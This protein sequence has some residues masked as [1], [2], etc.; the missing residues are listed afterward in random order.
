MR[1][2][3]LTINPAA[4][5]HN[6]AQVQ[7]LAPKAKVLA[8]VKANAYGHGVAAV[9]PAL[10][11]ADGVGVATFEEA[12]EARRLG[13]LKTIGLVEGVFSASEWQRAIDNEFSCVIHHAPQLEWA[14]DN[15]PPK[16]SQTRIV[17]LKYNSGM[18]RLGFNSDNIIEAAHA[19]NRSGYQLI[20]TTHFANADAF[21]HPLNTLQIKRFNALLETLRQDIS[22]DI[23]ASLCNSAGIIHFAQC[24][25]DWVRPGIMLYGSSPINDKSAAQL[26]LQPA[27]TFSTKIMAFQT[28]TA[29]DAIGYGSRWIAQQDTRTALISI[30]YGDGYPR[31]IDEQA[32]VCV[33][34]THVDGAKEHYFCPIRGRVAMDMIVIDISTTP[35][36]LPLNNDVILWGEAP[37]IDDVAAS[38][39]TISYELFCRLSLRPNRL[40]AN[41]IAERLEK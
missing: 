38:A 18:N 15:V 24:H 13:W 3:T 31:V 36:D 7:A 41:S 33:I 32:Q 19:L 14:L 20:L 26:N 16:D 40:V 30:G 28:V 12:L 25:Q 39:G 34:L 17:W 21:S 1:T 29:G 37:H 6:L 9:L 11:Q 10:D 4:I 27:M 23:Q 2:A 35:K 5:T 22:P 8:M